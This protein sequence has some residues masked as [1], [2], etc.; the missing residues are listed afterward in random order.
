M[1]GLRTGG[2]VAAIVMLKI[3]PALSGDVSIGLTS[4]REGSSARAAHDGSFI[5]AGNTAGPGGKLSIPQP[6]P[7]F[8]RAPTGTSERNATRAARDHWLEQQRLRQHGG[9]GKHYGRPGERQRESTSS[10]GVTCKQ[11]QSKT[12][13]AKKEK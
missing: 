1:Y 8:Q 11:P 12:C 7:T 2:V 3:A 10:S 4:A 5:V 6:R 13:L 9:S